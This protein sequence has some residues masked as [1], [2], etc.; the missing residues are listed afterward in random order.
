M[1]VLS[2]FAYCLGAGYYFWNGQHW[3]G[4]AFLGLAELASIHER[5]ARGPRK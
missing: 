4:M 3:E 5:L 1:N 2:I